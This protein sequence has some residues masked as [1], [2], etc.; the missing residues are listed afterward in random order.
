[1]RVMKMNRRKLLGFVSALL[2]PTVP[3][4]AISNS[5]GLTEVVKA[6]PSVGRGLITPVLIYYEDPELSY[7]KWIETVL[8]SGNQ[9]EK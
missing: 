8:Y 3:T 7:N 6:K 9:N 1:M 4:I 2:V 5:A